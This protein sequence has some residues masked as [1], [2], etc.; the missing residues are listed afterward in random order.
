MERH[1][2][3]QEL[4]QLHRLQEVI[5]E[6]GRRPYVATSSDGTIKVTA[7]ASGQIVGLEI[8]PRIY[9]DPNS[10][11]LARVIL[12]TL[13]QAIKGAASIHVDSLERVTGTGSFQELFQGATD[14]VRELMEESDDLR[15]RSR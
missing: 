5:Q 4:E 14:L 13:N 7:V 12:D 15:R 10:A 3:D 11:G 1:G 2:G 8:S 9:R 6:V